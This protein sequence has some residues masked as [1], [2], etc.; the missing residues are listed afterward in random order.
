[1]TTIIRYAIGEAVRRKV[2]LVVIILTAIFLG[3]EALANHYIF[4]D[5]KTS[6]CRRTCTS[7]RGRSRPRS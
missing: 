5:L 1:M 3:L 7:T 4:E 2:F 6:A